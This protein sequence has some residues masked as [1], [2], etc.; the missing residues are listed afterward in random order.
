MMP[1]SFLL[2]ARLSVAV[3]A[4][5][6]TVATADTP[7]YKCREDGETIYSATPCRDA[8]QAAVGRLDGRPEIRSARRPPAAGKARTVLTD[9]PSADTQAACLE[10]YRPL[11]RDPHSA[12]AVGGRLEQVRDPQRPEVSEWR[13]IV[14]DGRAT[15]SF[16][17][18]VPQSFV[19]ALTAEGDLAQDLTA[20]YRHLFS[21]GIDPRHM[22][23]YLPASR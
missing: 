3:W 9:A 19:C 5:A 7:I 15:N 16:G 1:P 22:D 13:E 12:Y 2:P 21:L 14:V 20:T 18:F 8:Q 17:G 4:I 23:I 6:T 10:A 11:L